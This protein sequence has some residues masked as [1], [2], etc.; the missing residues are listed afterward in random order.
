MNFFLRKMRHSGQGLLK[1]WL[2]ELPISDFVGKSIEIVFTGN[3]EC[4]RCSR[5]IKKTFGQG[6]CYPCFT[7]SA[8]CDICVL[9]PELCH[10]RKGTCREPQ[11][12]LEHCLIPHVV[13]LSHTS[14]LKVGITR[15]H[16]RFE[17]WGDQGATQAIVLAK[18]PER[19]FAGLVEAQLK[20]HVKDRTDWRALLKG[21]RSQIDMRIEAKRL[22]ECVQAEFSRYLLPNLDTAE[23]CELQYPIKVFPKKVLSWNPEKEPRVCGELEGIIGQYLIVGGKVINIRKYSGYEVEA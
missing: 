13:Y 15:E 17:R 10:F 20:A 5:K 11:W 18:V 12:G 8:E 3:I 16:K 2:G 1:Y 6:F 9:K 7:R 4:V 23:I 22:S 19:H 14:G 21:E